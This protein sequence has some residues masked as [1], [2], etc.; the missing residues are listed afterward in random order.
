MENAASTYSPDVALRHILDTVQTN[1]AHASVDERDI[2]L[3]PRIAGLLRA[4]PPEL[5]LPLLSAADDRRFRDGPPV[6]RLTACGR[7]A[8]VL[9]RL[10]RLASATVEGLASV[11]V[12]AA[13]ETGCQALL[14]RARSQDP[15]FRVGAGC[16]MIVSAL[17]RFT[18]DLA[19]L[20]E[21]PHPW[22]A[23]ALTDVLAPPWPERLRESLQRNLLRTDGRVRQQAAAVIKGW[24]QDHPGPVNE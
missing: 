8:V 6:L 19:A 9:G 2:V 15:R 20:L 4:P 1:W 5:R 12:A 16:G 10:L 7:L 21:D 13:L 17:E 23:G 3:L 22:V 18:P 24:L 14:E 11:E